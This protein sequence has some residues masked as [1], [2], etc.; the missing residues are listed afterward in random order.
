MSINTL[1]IVNKT[2]NNISLDG[3][4]KN[5][6][7][8]ILPFST[9][10]LY[11]HQIEEDTLFL[12]CLASLVYKE[13]IEV[14]LNFI[15][16]T[17][18][19][20][21]NIQQTMESLDNDETVSDMVFWVSPVGSDDVGTGT[22]TNPF[23][24]PI[25]LKDLL[26]KYKYINHEIKI[27][28]EP[29]TYDSFPDINISDH[30]IKGNGRV[31]LDASIGTFPVIEGP[32]TINTVTSPTPVGPLGANLATDIDTTAVPGWVV[33][34]H[35][36]NFIHF[37]SGLCSG[38]VHPIFKNT[39]TTLRFDADWYGAAPGDTFNIV[40]CPAVFNIDETV[41]IKGTFDTRLYF[42]SYTYLGIPDPPATPYLFLCGIEFKG[43]ANLP[44]TV[45]FD[46]IRAFISYTKINNNF[47][48]DTNGVGLYLIN[49]NINQSPI[50]TIFSKTE[51]NDWYVASFYVSMMGGAFDYNVLN[52]VCSS[53]SAFGV[54]VCNC[55]VNFV[56]S[57]VF[58]CLNILM[59]INGSAVLSALS[60]VYVEQDGA[61]Q[62]LDIYNAMIDLISVFINNSQYPVRFDASQSCLYWLQ[63]AS[64]TGSTGIRISIGATHIDIENLADVTLAG[65]ATSYTYEFGPLSFANYPAIGTTTNDTAGSFM[66]TRS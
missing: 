48:L 61:H 22:I 62:G 49:C 18:D 8:L 44:T 30:I 55:P 66:K 33:N 7:F 38:Q 59:I 52:G 6:S 11:P 45:I 2:R 56:N 3:D 43:N 32:F 15:V 12:S 60:Y 47:V 19:Q 27:N 34:E 58:G 53:Y 64:T 9:L 54:L 13:D 5:N 26:K 14:I 23:R 39:A 17:P 20:I 37:T 40:S 10:N 29:G 36:G 35:A 41:M 25:F 4:L 16:L 31:V 1:K 28:I 50:P 21:L 63:G 46:T 57:F 65:T 42:N 51:L 24:T